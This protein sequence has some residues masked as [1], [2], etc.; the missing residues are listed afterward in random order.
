MEPVVLP[1][2][3][4]LND[5][6]P[7]NWILD[8]A[9]NRPSRIIKSLL[10]DPMIEEE[11]N[12]KLVRKYQAIT[13][14]IVA[15]ETYLVEDARLVLVAYGTAARIA[16]GAVKKARE[17]GLKIGLCRPLTL[18]P[19]PKQILSDLEQAGKEF[20]VLEMSTGQ[21]LEDV[22]LSLCKRDQIHF[23]GRPGGTVF[24]PDE[25]TKVAGAF[26]YQRRLDKE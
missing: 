22:Q 21:M 5:L 26:Y 16:K 9:R 10:L 1:E 15:A 11:H 25:I 2:P 19:F 14:K 18:W 8:G 3:I 4:N 12:W 13:A 6:P 23:Y 17:Q 20:L 24:T 7:K